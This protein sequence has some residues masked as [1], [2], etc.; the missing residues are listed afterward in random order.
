MNIRLVLL[1]RGRER[2]GVE[3]KRDLDRRTPPWA[4]PLSGLTQ[5]A[6]RFFK[7]YL[8]FRLLSLRQLSPSSLSLSL[9]SFLRPLPPKVTAERLDLAP[10]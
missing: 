4:K 3:E 5:R 9:H 10:S 1:G 7:L 8:R 6:S 2:K